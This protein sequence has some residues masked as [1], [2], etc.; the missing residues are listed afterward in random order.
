MEFDIPVADLPS[1]NPDFK[2]YVKVLHE[3]G[4]LTTSDLVTSYLSCSLGS[5]KG[6]GRKFF[7]TLQDFVSNQHRYKKSYKELHPEW[8]P[9]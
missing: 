8:S 7:A 5:V 6:L 1:L 9:A 2:R 3:N 4:I